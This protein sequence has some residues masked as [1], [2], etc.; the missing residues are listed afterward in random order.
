[1][2]AERR[3]T[4][5]ARGNWLLN[6]YVATGRRARAYLLDFQILAGLMLAFLTLADWGVVPNR[7]GPA[8]IWSG[9]AVFVLYEPLMVRLVGGTLGHR[10]MG[11]RVV[12]PS[13]GPLALPRA[14]VRTLVKWVTIGYA[15]PVMVGLRS[16]RAPWD[17]V[18]GSLVVDESQGW[19]R[20]DATAVGQLGG[21]R[22]PRDWHRLLRPISQS[23]R[24]DDVSTPFS[25]SDSCRSESGDALL[26]T[27]P[28]P[29]VAV[30]WPAHPHHP[31]R[32]RSSAMCATWWRECHEYNCACMAN[33]IIPRSG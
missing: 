15:G 2:A 20:R 22:S 17:V 18:V 6:S 7:L 26:R 21:Q 14:I 1:M 29:R 16:R 24:F 28:S 10:L 11:L 23:V 4:R 31:S 27:T 25:L 30:T 12:G 32:R 3:P 5:A 19:P 9:M 8:L 13:G 33:V